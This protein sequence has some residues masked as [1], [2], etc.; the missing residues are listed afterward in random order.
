MGPYYLT[1]LVNLLGPMVRVTGFASK[2]Q[3]ERFAAMPGTRIEVTTPTHVTGAIEF[4]S[5]AVATVILSFDVWQHTL[6]PMEV[7]GTDGSLQA[8]DPNLTGG[9]PRIYRPEKKA[10]EDVP[11]AYPTI[12][13]KEYGRGIGVAEMAEAI[14]AGRPHRANDT[15]ALHVVDAMEAFLESGAKGRAVRMRTTCERP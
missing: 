12:Y 6:P 3:K 10:W 2:G 9:T 14:I 8:A 4:A 1:A 13:P 15:V 5:G 7:F 11:L